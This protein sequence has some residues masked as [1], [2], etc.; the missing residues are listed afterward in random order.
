MNLVDLKN[1]FG[2][3]SVDMTAHYIGLDE[4][5]MREGLA[6]FDA[7]MVPL[8]AVSLSQPLGAEA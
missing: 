5:H 1:F 2:H 8:L 6:K 4:D 7:K 3:K